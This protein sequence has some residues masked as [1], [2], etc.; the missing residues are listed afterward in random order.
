MA[1]LSSRLD[2]V[3]CADAS[4]WRWS[5]GCAV[6]ACLISWQ[7]AA[8]VEPPPETP[9]DSVVES[10]HGEFTADP[11]RWLEDTES[12][13]TRDWFEA[14]N[15][16]AR[17]R[18]DA[19]PGRAPLRAEIASLLSANADVSDVK[20]AGDRVFALRREAGAP[21]Y[22]LVLRN[23]VDGAERVVL[24]PSRFRTPSEAA[25]IDY[26]LP[27]P[28]GRLV[29]AA[30]SLGG[31]EA[32]TVHVID[33]ESGNE[34]G[35]PIPRADFGALAWR[36]DSAVLYYRQARDLP[37]DADPADKYRDAAVRM[38]E[39][40]DA[41]PGADVAV[42]GRTV[43]AGLPIGP[44]DLPEVFVSPVSSWAL[45]IVRHGVAR[46]LTVFAVP[47]TLLRGPETPWRKVVDRAQRV[48]DVDLR[49]EWL[50]LRTSED[51]P[52]F[53]LLRW[54]LK[55][56]LPYRVEG[57]EVVLPQGAAILAAFAVARDALYVHAR[58]VG[59]ARLLRLEFNVRIVSMPP[60]RRSRGKP[61]PA[62]LPKLAGVARST[63]IA[64]PFAG[65]VSDL[66]VDPLHPGAWVRLSG[67]TEPPGYFTVAPLSGAVTRTPILARSTVSFGDVA[68]T[69]VEVASHDGV[70]VPMT[71]VAPR[72]AARD[73]R[74]PALVVAYGAYGYALEP[75]FRPWMKAWL[76]RG[77]IYAVA[78]VRGGGEHGPEWHLAGQKARKANSWLDLVACAEHLVADRHAD[79]RKLA[80]R[81]ASAG[82]LAVVN[83]MEARPDLFHAIVSEVGFHDAVRGE[84]AATGPAN[85]E[86]FG[87]VATEDGYRTLVAMSAYAN[88]RE[89]AAYPAVLF[90]AGYNDPRVLPWDPGKMAARLQ[91]IGAAPGGSGNPVL[92]RT[93][94]AG[95]H[96]NDATLDAIVDET[97]DVLAF[98]LW[99]AGVAGFAPPPD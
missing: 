76:D 62:A 15:A 20:R 95:G 16:Y 30:V 74:A 72:A 8:A 37:S 82:G 55:S 26:Y 48:E 1:R 75:A 81:G 91:S 63:E 35:A 94:F 53:R 92:L 38:R 84:L 13:A 32:S 57:A 86:E 66:V 54:S 52:R 50:Y 93:D 59:E 90:T 47:L 25:A 18:L 34:V 6:A 39:F 2:V 10:Y 27:A 80:I 69:R 33:V 31:R 29:A 70:R 45:G 49:G 96:G 98:L 83:A 7:V 28:N 73:G 97:T 43:G 19:L 22:R 46:E 36:F 67:W 61:A 23:G 60:A 68:V 78:H 4:A 51:A 42:M 56:S 71:I 9:V 79:R 85:V 44:N 17:T 89:G 88:A 58:D 12:A 24:D 14:Q 99:Q 3:G 65:S 64:L 40:R 77:G 41:V 21:S 11:Y 87:S 5:R